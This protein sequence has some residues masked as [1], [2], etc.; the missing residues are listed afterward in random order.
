MPT[1]AA[2]DPEAP[3]DLPLPPDRKPVARR[4]RVPRRSSRLVFESVLIV[5]SVLLGFAVSEWRDQAEDRR[6]A[7][8]ALAN[9]RRE[10]AANLATLEAVQPRHERI[11]RALSTADAAA[12]PS[13]SAF[14]V[15]ERVL[16]EGGIDVRPLR[17]AAWETA[18]AT[19][20][21]RLV[22]YETAA[23][24]SEAYLVQRQVIGMTIGRL[25]DRFFDPRS[26]SPESRAEMLPM[27]G[28]LLNELASQE[29]YL[30]EIYRNTLE[31]L[32]PAPDEEADE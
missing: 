22:E 16:P 28:M 5:L 31:R 17:D 10:I 9:F 25:S 7:R 27:F 11:A 32:P 14:G 24:L 18:S 2:A 21:L 8:T 13:L 1:T 29:A 30:M 26:F 19:G 23:A 12:Y 6:L 4:R 15:I 3:L 20:A